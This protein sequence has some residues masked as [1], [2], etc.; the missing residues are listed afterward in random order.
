[1][2]KQKIVEQFVDATGH[3]VAAALNALEHS[4]QLKIAEELEGGQANITIKMEPMTASIRAYI[5]TPRG[6]V[7]LFAIRPPMA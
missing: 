4:A 7:D 3:L 6:D 5:E 2:N 1:M